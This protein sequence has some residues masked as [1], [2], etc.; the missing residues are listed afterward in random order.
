MISLRSFWL[1]IIF[2]EENKHFCIFSPR[3]TLGP[4]TLS[5]RTPEAA[6]Q[7]WRSR[8]RCTLSPSSH[9]APR[10]ARPWPLCERTSSPPFQG[11]SKCIVSPSKAKRLTGWIPAGWVTANYYFLNNVVTLFCGFFSGS[12]P[13]RTTAANHAQTSPFQ[14]THLRLSI[15]R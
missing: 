15:P 5:K 4:L 7:N 1:F 10:S 3:T 11:A 13:T 9:L 6:P 12:H 8:A 2:E 14:R